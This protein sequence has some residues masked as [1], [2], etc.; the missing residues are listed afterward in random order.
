MLDG[1]KIREDFPIFQRKI[2]GRDLVFLDTAASSQKPNCVIDALSQFYRESNANVHRGLYVLS[3]EST[4]KLEQT[5]THVAD[6]AGA[7]PDEYY[8]VFVRGTTEAINLVA[9]SHALQNLGAGD[10]I[11]ITELEHHANLVPWQM[12][13][14]QTGATL[15]YAR[16]DDDGRLDLDHF[17]DQVNDKTRLVSFVHASNVLGTINPAKEIVSRLN[18]RGIV[19]MID[20]AQA[21]PTMPVDVSDIGCSAYAFSAHKMLGPTGVGVLFLKKELADTMVP[22][23]FGGGMIFKV[24]YDTTR[25]AEPPERFEA[26]TP[27]FAEI[28]AF[29]TALSYL[30]ELGMD[31]VLQHEQKM[32]SYMLETLRQIDGL[33]IY[34]PPDDQDRLAI[35]S[36]ELDNIHA[37]DLGMFLDFQGI[38]VRVGHHCA[39]PLMEKLGTT[40]TTRASA[41][42]YNC[43]EDIDLLASA[44]KD[45]QSYFLR[46]LG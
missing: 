15:R 43:E 18:E 32:A 12:V 23:Q 19:T 27:A 9:S 16:I 7:N 6:F 38:C 2:R 39:Q 20:G 37:H 25:F 40:S 5:R 35:V 1:R 46:T 24:K 29:S 17:F 22:Y 31:N 42:I 13:A 36:F 34:G 33:K 8:T 26:G 3:M 45:A 41:Y 10:E 14:K 4:H 21:V 44:L 11:V 28:A 30:E